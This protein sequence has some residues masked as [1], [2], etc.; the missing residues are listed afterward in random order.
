MAFALLGVAMWLLLA[1]AGWKY[2][3]SRRSLARFDRIG[4][5]VFFLVIGVPV[6]VVGS[7]LIVTSIV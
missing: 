6:L 2:S 1:M 7:A 4:A 3:S 5:L